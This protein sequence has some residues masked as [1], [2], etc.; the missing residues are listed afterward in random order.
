MSSFTFQRRENKNPVSSAAFQRRE[1]NTLLN[2]RAILPLD[3]DNYG[4]FE[5]SLHQLPRTLNSEIKLVFPD[6]A[7][8]TQSRDITR[9]LLAIPTYQTAAFPILEINDETEAERLRLFIRFKKYAQDFSEH[10]SQIDPDSLLDIPDIDGSATFTR[11]TVTIY[12][13][14]SSTRAILGYSTFLYMGVQIVQ[15][16]RMGYAKLAVHT[17]LVYARPDDAKEAFRRIEKVFGESTT[18]PSDK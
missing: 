9:K 2:P 13:E 14:V 7:S 18:S 12:D 1:K 6:L 3:E 8:Q 4:C 11:S 10:L 15:H 16:P 5:A 17:V